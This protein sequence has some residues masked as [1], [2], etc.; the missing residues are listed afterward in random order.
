VRFIAQY[1][2]PL[3]S[4]ERIKVR[5]H[6][7]RTTS[8]EI[9][10]ATMSDKEKKEEKKGVEVDFGLGK[11]SLG[12]LGGIFEGVGNLIDLA[13]KLSEVKEIRREGEIKG[14]G[15]KTKG[16]YGFSIKTLVGGKPVVETFG[17][18]KR[19]KEGPVIEEVREPIV[20]VLKEENFI[21]VIAEL[22]GVSKENV[23]IKVNED[24]LNLSA[25]K[26]ER[27]Y[28]KEILLPF[29]VKED[30]VEFSFKNGMLE[31]K[32]EKKES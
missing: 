18:I 32:L 20:D 1:L 24:I 6:E 21:R 27:K 12:G 11:I 23:K 28:A 14:L 29:S 2:S 31:L 17:N 15:G 8:N 30:P 5:G 22:P 9:K 10:E 3:P 26:G 25:E 4:G 19:E 16:V 13:S 7:R